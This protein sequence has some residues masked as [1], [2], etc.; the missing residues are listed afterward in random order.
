MDALIITRPDFTPV[1]ATDDYTLDLAYGNSENNFELTV[2]D[3]S[4][5]KLTG[6]EYV[7]I[8]G[9]PWWSGGFDRAQHTNQYNHIPWT[10]VFWFVG[11]CNNRTPARCRL[12]RAHNHASDL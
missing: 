7:Y 8:D 9:S 6:G 2:D 10:F 4:A 5:P 3:P 1:F 12:Q 11:I